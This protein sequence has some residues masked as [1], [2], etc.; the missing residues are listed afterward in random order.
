[1]EIRPGFVYFITTGLF[2]HSQNPYPILAIALW[3]YSLY[4]V[5]INVGMQF[6]YRY[7]IVCMA[8]KWSSLKFFFIYCLASLY[9]LW[10]SVSYVLVFEGVTKEYT[11]ELKTN[12]MYAFETPSYAA[13][14]MVR[15][16]MV[17][18]C[19]CTFYCRH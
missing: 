12:P 14:D 10:M 7:N 9:P 6:L 4:I 18:Q 13:C 1:M 15:V 3:L 16:L 5:T 19:Y 2:T 11:K 17:L 8:K